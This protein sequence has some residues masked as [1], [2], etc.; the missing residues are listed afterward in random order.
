M[1]F[2]AAIANMANNDLGNLAPNLNSKVEF[3]QF[4]FHSIFSENLVERFNLLLIPRFEVFFKIYS[5]ISSYIYILFYILSYLLI[6]LWLCGL[7]W[8]ADSQFKGVHSDG[9]HDLKRQCDADVADQSRVRL[10]WYCAHWQSVQPW[11]RLTVHQVHA[12]HCPAKQ[13]YLPSN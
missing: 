1:V 5:F 11:P 10:G 12:E 2:I 9:G 3:C 8:I 13:Q 4:N 6:K 7:I